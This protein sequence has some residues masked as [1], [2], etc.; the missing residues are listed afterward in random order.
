MEVEGVVDLFQDNGSLFP[1][2]ISAPSIPFVIPPSSWTTIS[3]HNKG[4]IATGYAKVFSNAPVTIEGRFLNPQFATSVAAATP[5]TSR[6]V[7]LLAAAG[8]SATQD[9]AV[10]LI[11]SSAGTLNLSLSNS[12]GLPI[13]SRTIDVT[14]GQH[15]ATFV[16]QLMPSVH[17]GVISGR[18]TIT[19]SAGVISVIALQFDTS[20]SPITVTPLP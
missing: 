10:A 17:G 1:A 7:S 3:T 4:A 12:F 5:V 2:S 15:I 16:S 11:A 6:S 9:T 13:A 20:L 14:A 19:A 18:L 8:G